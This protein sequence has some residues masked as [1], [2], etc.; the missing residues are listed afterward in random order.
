MLSDSNE[1]R[2]QNQVAELSQIILEGTDMNLIE[3]STAVRCRS[4]EDDDEKD[5]NDCEI[6][7][8][9]D[10]EDA[11]GFVEDIHISAQCLMDLIPSM[12]QILQRQTI[13]KSS[14]QFE[15]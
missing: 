3:I 2:L 10:D 6:N 4:I 11:D 15:E 7:D 5:A 1:G 13:M 12:E 9:E 8:D 14:L